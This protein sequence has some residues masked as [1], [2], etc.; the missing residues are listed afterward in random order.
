ME[1]SDVCFDRKN[2]E[3]CNIEPG[4]PG[5]KLSDE[6]IASFKVPNDG[7]ERFG[8]IGIDFD[9][10][11]TD[12]GSLLLIVENWS[13]RKG[14]RNCCVMGKF[15]SL[16]EMKGWGIREDSYEVELPGKL[17]RKAENAFL[18]RVIADVLMR[19]RPGRDVPGLFSSGDAPPRDCA[20]PGVESPDTGAASARVQ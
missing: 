8:S 2:G 13:R 7:E 5:L 3:R 4:R 15:G 1:R 12:E 20:C 11:L 18:A 16:A 10:Y 17:I 19:I 9:L 14:G 6:K